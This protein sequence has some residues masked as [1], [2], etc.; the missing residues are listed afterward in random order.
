MIYSAGENV[1][2]IHS[3]FCDITVEYLDSKKWSR[4]NYGKPYGGV[5]TPNQRIFPWYPFLITVK[6]SGSQIVSLGEFSLSSGEYN[7]SALG[8]E[9][10]NNLSGALGITDL[11]ALT[12][13]RLYHGFQKSFDRMDIAAES[14]PYEFS[15]IL[16]GDRLVLVVLFKAPPAH[17]NRFSIKAQITG[18]K[19]KK[20]VELPLV[21][22]IY[23]VSDDSLK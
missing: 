1:G 16:P 19:E 21:R 18:E 5:Y 17:I 9:D 7:S 4:L 20:T 6:N 10:L 13:Y 22:R 14:T 12:G 3:M 15:R 11:S 2:V 8:K 23:R